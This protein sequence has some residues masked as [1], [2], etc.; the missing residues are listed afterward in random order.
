MNKIYLSN[1]GICCAAGN[2]LNEL[3]DHVFSGNQDGI[4]KTAVLNDEFTVAHLDCSDYEPVD[5]FY[6][7]KITRIENT[8]IKQLEKE[9]L[10]VRD[11]FSSDRIAVC[12][13]SCDNGSEL[14]NQAHRSYFKN[15]K[16]PS[17][18]ELTQQ[19][20][21]GSAAFIKE[22]YNISGPAFGFAT[23]CASSAQA[24]INGAQLI[25]SGLADAVIAGGVDLASATPLEGFSSLES[26][27]ENITN[28]FSKNRNGI[29]LGDAAAFFILS[30]EPF[31]AINS[32]EQL[33]LLGYGETSDA[34][35]ITSPDP[36]G[37]GAI[38]AMEKA[39][40]SAHLKASQIDYINLHG[41][42]TKAN[43][44]AESKA[45]TTVFGNQVP[46]SSTK[47]ITGHT[48]GAAGALELAIC[49]GAIQ[50]QKLPVHVWD[51][52]YDTTLPALDFVKQDFIVE[53]PVLKCLSN[54]FAFGGSNASLIIGK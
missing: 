25:K 29:T 44:S 12:V 4:K 35:H 45:V 8:A 7:T 27:A 6:D 39:L 15:G 13:G 1:P 33:K 28:P 43:D 30:K 34:Y 42:G 36:D 16:F 10:Y 38:K 26:L 22:K 2:S 11:H 32:D 52:E 54:S 23:A 50:E 3:L 21:A 17:E 46:V 9:V 41:T 53:K 40:Q 51:E 18:Y 48:L 20:G 19:G 5:I 31:P 24:I 37:K 49:Y 47:P 14:S